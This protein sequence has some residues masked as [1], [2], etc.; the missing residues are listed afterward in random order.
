M[1]W[2]YFVRIIKY[3][4]PTLRHKSKPLRRV[5][6]DLVSI[7]RQMFD[8]MHEH[9]GLGLAANQVELPYRLFILQLDNDEGKKKV[10]SWCSSTRLSPKGRG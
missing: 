7:V 10:R 3:P 4:H 5:D 9:R 1:P 6:R 2:S 8:L